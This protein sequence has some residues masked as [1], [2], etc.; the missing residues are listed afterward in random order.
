MF[1]QGKVS[2]E[3][4]SKPFVKASVKGGAIAFVIF[5]VLY[6]PNYIAL[7]WVWIL[8]Y[9][10]AFIAIQR[11]LQSYL[12]ERATSKRLRSEVQHLLIQAD[13]HQTKQKRK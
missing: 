6:L 13:K 2:D 3:Y 10:I 9:L 7:G 4:D 5:I 11:F 1:D 12:Q 8:S